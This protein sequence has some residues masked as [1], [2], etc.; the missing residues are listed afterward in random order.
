VKVSFVAGFGPIVPEPHASRSFW[1]DGLGIQLEEAAPAYF[2]TDD[3][4]GV[5]A[6]ALWPLSQAAEST[7]GTDAWPADVPVPQAWLELDVESAEAVGEAVAELEG[8]GYRL[9]R[10]AHEEPWGQTTSRLQS[11]EGLL[12][13]ITFTPWMHKDPAEPA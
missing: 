4:P 11:P 9:L 10:G 7:F 12:V 2:A 3:L 1:S 13:G 5:R 6:F 8:R